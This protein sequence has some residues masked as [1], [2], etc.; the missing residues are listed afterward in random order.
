MNQKGY[1]PSISPLH[2]SV[3][4]VETLRALNCWIDARL[5]MELTCHWL[6]AAAPEL[7]HAV[8]S[9]EQLRLERLPLSVPCTKWFETTV[10][11]LLHQLGHRGLL[12]EE[13]GFPSAYACVICQRPR[14][15][16]SRAALV[17]DA[18]LFPPAEP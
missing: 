15:K 14:E 4:W 5:G 17:S 6:C 3:Q 16:L 12:F 1:L 7:Q 13:L 2:L 9:F 11:A 10:V 18:L 8:S